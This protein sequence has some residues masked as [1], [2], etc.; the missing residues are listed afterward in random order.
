M[1][2]AVPEAVVRCLIAEDLGCL[3]VVVTL[4]VLVAANAVHREK[5]KANGGNVQA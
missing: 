2:A 5:E 4:L 1:V 3:D